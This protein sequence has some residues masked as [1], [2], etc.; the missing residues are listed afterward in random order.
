MF[1]KQVKDQVAKR[2]ICSN[3]DETEEIETKLQ[4]A[5]MLLNLRMANYN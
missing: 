3:S 5:G 2:S 1:F 4:N